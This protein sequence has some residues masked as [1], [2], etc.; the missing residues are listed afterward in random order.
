[1]ASG[2]AGA[3]KV[4]LQAGGLSLPLTD[5]STMTVQTM[6][7]DVEAITDTR[8][9]WTFNNPLFTE[10]YNTTHSFWCHCVIQTASNGG[11]EYAP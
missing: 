3:D 6:G 7:K 5:K 1:M 4:S 8:K 11:I 9:S 2:R 10:A